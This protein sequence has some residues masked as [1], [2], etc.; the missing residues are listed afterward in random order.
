MKHIVVYSHGFGVDSTDR[1]LFTDIAAALPEAEHSMFD[2]NQLSGGT[3]TVSPLDQQAHRVGDKLTA[4]KSKYPHGTID[5]ICHSQGCI[6]AAMARPMGIRR[7]IC[8][9]PLEVVDVQRML[10]R[11]STRPGAKIDPNG[12]TTLPRRDGS[13]TSVPTEYW[14]S[15]RN[16]SP[17]S[18]YNA[19]AAHVSLTLITAS[20]DEVIGATNFR[21]LDPSIEVIRITADH[22][23]NG[24]SRQELIA[25]IKIILL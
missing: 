8:I 25:A 6:V 11:F 19:L 15:L 21:K 16:I 7:V 13:T 24:K 9:A 1:G 18:L 5:L 22:D 10:Q 4:T 14:R 20:Q 12:M 23:F 2:Y 3:L 17:V